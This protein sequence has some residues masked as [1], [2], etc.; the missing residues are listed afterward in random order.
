MFCLG[1]NVATLFLYCL[2]Y[3]SI[4]K[5]K[6]FI[7]IC[8]LTDDLIERKREGSSTVMIRYITLF[9]CFMSRGKARHRTAT[10]III[11]VFSSLLLCMLS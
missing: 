6:N 1:R 11:S 10:F 8:G 5:K 3:V 9:L 7:W 4:R 2:P